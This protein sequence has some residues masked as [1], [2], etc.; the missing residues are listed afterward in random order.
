MTRWPLYLAALFIICG[1]SLAITG[2]SS[3]YGKSQMPI[4]TEKK[5]IR[6][7]KLCIRECRAIGA[8]ELALQLQRELD[9]CQHDPAM[10]FVVQER[11]D[12]LLPAFQYDE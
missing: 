8:Y 1:I 7:A 10:F 6:D 2:C 3:R 12:E 5:I 11:V 9:A 4:P